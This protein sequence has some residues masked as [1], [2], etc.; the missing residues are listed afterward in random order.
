MISEGTRSTT[1]VT[2]LGT[3]SSKVT[4]KIK[5]KF[6]N[7]TTSSNSRTAIT[8]MSTRRMTSTTGQVTSSENS[9]PPTLKTSIAPTTT[10]TSTK[11][12]IILPTS[13]KLKK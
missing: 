7:S 11:G 1:V 2:T 5:L 10:A 12:N 8:K 3:K 6:P 9:K 13:C 4:T